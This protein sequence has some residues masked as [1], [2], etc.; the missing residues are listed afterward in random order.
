[1][2][3]RLDDK[4]KYLESKSTH[5]RSNK[6]EDQ[7]NYLRGPREGIRRPRR[8]KEWQLQMILLCTRQV[9]QSCWWLG[10]EIASHTLRH[11]CSLN[12]DGAWTYA[13]AAAEQHTN[14]YF[15]PTR[16]CSAYQTQGTWNHANEKVN[17]NLV[18]LSK[19][20]LGQIRPPPSANRGRIVVKQFSIP[21]CEVEEHEDHIERGQE[22]HRNA[23]HHQ[24]LAKASRVTCE[25]SVYQKVA[26]VHH[27][28]S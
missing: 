6:N 14:H 16:N 4:G 24:P 22:Q 12:S 1:M 25:I 5:A 28:E 10:M 9:L 23:Q 17:Y 2:K 3:N 20:P 15:R 13:P 11:A 26:A 7:V 8:W 18:K 27:I 19:A 21:K